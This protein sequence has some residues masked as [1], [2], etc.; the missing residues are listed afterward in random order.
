MGGLALA[1]AGVKRKNARDYLSVVTSILSI[2][3]ILFPNVQSEVIQAY[4]NKPTFGDADILIESDNLPPDWVQQVCLRCS[5]RDLHS[6]GGVIS[7]EH[8][9][10]QVDLITMKSENFA[11]AQVYFAYNDLGNLMGR[12]AHKMGF[13]YDHD[14]LWKVM[15]DGTHNFANMLI[16]RDPHAVFSLLGYDYSRWLNGFNELDDI[17]E[18][19]SSS[20]YFHRD[21]Y[22]LHNRNHI[23]RVRDEKRP[24][25]TAFLKWIEVRPELD[26]Y[27]WSVYS[28]DK[29]STQRDEEKAYW[30]IV[31]LAS[32]PE[33]KLQYDEVMQAYQKSK[34]MKRI[35]NGNIVR[36]ITGL[37]GK[38]LGAFM[39]HCREHEIP[40]TLT[41]PDAIKKATQVCF[42]EYQN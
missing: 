4:R 3:R 11:F 19:A 20:P 25:Y 41:D 1:R 32:F 10:M 36:E 26:R 23:S 35:W 6:N 28:Q 8:M 21:I 5:P 27:T 34:E 13:K 9:D 24:T 37:T 7:I 14:G 22:Q 40:G 15:R 39:A 29:P 17:F 18:F 30:L 42:T 31:A 2:L 16:S 38:E 12:V 33:F